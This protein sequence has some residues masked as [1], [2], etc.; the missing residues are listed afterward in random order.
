M[1]IQIHEGTSEEAINFFKQSFKVLLF[2][3]ESQRIIGSWPDI[4]YED[5]EY[6]NMIDILSVGLGVTLGMLEKSKGVEE[7]ATVYFSG[8]LKKL[9]KNYS[10]LL[11]GVSEKVLAEFK[12]LETSA[13]SIKLKTKEGEKDRK[14]AITMFCLQ[15]HKIIFKKRFFEIFYGNMVRQEDGINILE[16][17]RFLRIIFSF[18]EEK[19]LTNL[20][21][22]LEK[23]FH[24]NPKLL[25]EQN[26]SHLLEKEMKFFE[27]IT[28]NGKISL[29]YSLEEGRAF[30]DWR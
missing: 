15:G 20:K 10:E 18:F 6:Q 9:V 17:E 28:K 3:L 1:S 4:V 21:N 24:N 5:K 12:M 22:S 16:A 23:K 26:I 30:L 27:K 19:I 2:D 11:S 7:E 25:D 8:A 14:F 13:I 29:D